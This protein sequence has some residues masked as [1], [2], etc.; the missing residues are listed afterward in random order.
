MSDLRESGAIEQDADSIVFVYRDEY[1]HHDSKAK[2]RAEL[3]IAKQR[4]GSEGRAIVGFDGAF[5]MF[6]EL[7][8]GEQ[9]QLEREAQDEAYAPRRTTGKGRYGGG[10]HT[11]GDQ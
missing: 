7:T 6:R 1:Y 2:G 10:Y 11:G 5:T 4:N 8:D 9:A 3:I